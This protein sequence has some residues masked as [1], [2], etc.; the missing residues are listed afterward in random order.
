MWK[1]RGMFT[2]STSIAMTSEVVTMLVISGVVAVAF[3][4]LWL[5]MLRRCAGHIIYISVLFNALLYFAAAI[6]SIYYGIVISA[7][8]FIIFG[9]LALL[10]LY[11]VRN[12]IKFT[13]AILKVSISGLQQFWGVFLSAVGAAIISAAYMVF[14]SYAV[15][16]IVSVV[17][18]DAYQEDPTA[19]P[20]Q[21]S[22]FLWFLLALSL[23]WTIE[24][25]R[26]IHFTATAGAIGT[27]WYNSTANFATGASLKRASVYSLGSIALGSFIVAFLQ[28]LRYMLRA[29]SDGRGSFAAACLEC[30][31]QLIE[32]IVRYFNM[33]AYVQIALYG[34]DFMTAASDT[35]DLFAAKGFEMIINDDLTGLVVV[36]GSFV[37]GALNALVVGLPYFLTLDDDS[38]YGDNTFIVFILCFL[39][40]FLIAGMLLSQLA[41][42]AT[43]TFVVWAEDADA[44][45]QTRPAE[46][47]AIT[48]ARAKYYS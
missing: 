7:V 36:F 12:R 38:Q 45:Q 15:N 34:K 18:Y 25:V 47:A 29:S 24:T 20:T 40:G 17:E 2:S 4:V 14:W 10:Y 19:D 37:G 42:A 27:W 31:L 39:M 44:M 11:C 16:A 13:E 33:Y 28:T 1:D 32:N 26:N 43:T 8:I 21:L 46:F 35:M 22:G 41:A 5:A 23:Y 3:S 9:L 30:L 6:A 48:E